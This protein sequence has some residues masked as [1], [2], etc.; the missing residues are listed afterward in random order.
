R[1]DGRDPRRARGFRGCR[2]GPRRIPDSAGRDGARR[3]R[4]GSDHSLRRIAQAG[5]GRLSST[6]T[7]EPAGGA[8]G[9]SAEQEK[10]IR[11]MSGSRFAAAL[12]AMLML[13][14]ASAQLADL[15]EALRTTPITTEQV[16]DNLY[17]MFGVGGAI[18][19]SL[20]AQGG[21]LAE[22]A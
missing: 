7:C 18:L 16:G 9:S 13:P 6:S 4:D 8:A 11:A 14:A 15:S 19:A 5:K 2:R 1:K 10:R 12:A 20:G 21:G 3:F 17:V 22:S